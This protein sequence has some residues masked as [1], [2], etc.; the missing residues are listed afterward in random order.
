MKILHLSVSDKRGAFEATRR[1]H[2]A[3]Q[4]KGHESAMI[5]QKKNTTNDTVI[6][7]KSLTA[8]Q[9]LW[10]WLV[11]KVVRWEGDYYFF[12]TCE[13]IPFSHAKNI[14]ALLPFTP[15]IVMLHWISRFI[16]TRTIHEIQK[17]TQ[18]QI[19]WHLL[20]MAP[21]TGGCHYAWQCRGYLKR[22]G[23][24]P[25]IRSR[26]YYDLSSINLFIKQKYLQRVHPVIIAPSNELY[27]QCKNSMLFK[28]NTI[29]K[30]L[31]PLD[32]KEFYPG[33][34]NELRKRHTIPLLKKVICFRSDIPNQRRKGFE[35]IV[36]SL[37]LLNKRQVN[38]I[39][40]VIIGKIS[41]TDRKKIIFP[42]TIFSSLKSNIELGNVYRLSDVF[43][44]VSLQDSGPMMINEAI[45]SG[46]PV[47]SFPVG[48]TKDLVIEGKT[49]FIARMKDPIDLANKINI[50]LSM[51]AYLYKKMT[52]SCRKL[53]IEKL[54]FPAVVKQYEQ[55]LSFSK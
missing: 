2:Q 31:L 9:K 30:I 54:G 48:V 17:I 5:V 7:Y 16:N 51:N 21:M 36:K 43:L 28:T 12:N 49:G 39:H 41:E 46:L 34:K 42:Y 40:I 3:F 55:I 35:Y 29:H 4:D 50:L 6:Q 13:F 47:I 1:L 44:C 38:N 22:C 11:D 45:A 20:D 24:C 37:S 14:L 15:D 27:E 10:N 33:H 53:A 8:L 52:K 32:L 18:A 23:H 26:F 19:I 25:A